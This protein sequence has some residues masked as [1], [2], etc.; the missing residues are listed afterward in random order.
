M[1][2]EDFLPLIEDAGV[3]GKIRDASIVL[4]R[5]NKMKLS[6]IGV[7][8]KKV[9]Q[10]YERVYHIGNC[11]FIEKSW[12]LGQARINVDNA[13]SHGE[14]VYG[15]EFMDSSRRFL[16]DG[17]MHY[18]KENQEIE[19]EQYE[20]YAKQVECLTKIVG[21]ESRKDIK[22]ASKKY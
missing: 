20:Q 16:N 2:V 18:F 8:I 1:P 11:E 3:R 19:R 6:K 14:M 21:F 5:I 13:I 12:E 7:V 10:G 22:L 4:S 9:N 15:K 17:K